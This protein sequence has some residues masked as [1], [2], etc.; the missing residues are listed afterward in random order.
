[1][2]NTILPMPEDINLQV[3]TIA[4]TE[5]V[6]N[7]GSSMVFDYAV[8][9]KPC[10]YINYDVVHKVRPDWSVKNIYNYVHFR[11]IPN[12]KV[13]IW[14]N[15]PEEIASKIEKT[16]I[17]SAETVAFAKNWFEVIN[18]QPPQEASKRMWESI[19]KII[20]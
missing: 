4:H 6:I 9:N 17:D 10:A 15:N 16:L 18:Q 19:K 7:L 8:H 5:M 13:V 2:W 3:N 14:L 20:Q 11:S 1:M 12:A